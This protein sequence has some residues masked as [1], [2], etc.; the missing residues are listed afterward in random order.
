VI[1]D[2]L[3]LVGKLDGEIES[4]DKPLQYTFDEGILLLKG[5]QIQ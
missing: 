3:C 4:F 5:I 2:R 1:T